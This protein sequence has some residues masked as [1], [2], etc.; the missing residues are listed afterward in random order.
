MEYMF[1]G[2]F[3]L[4][5]INITHFDTSR[6]TSFVSMFDNCCKLKLLDFSDI[7]N[8]YMITPTI[9]LYSLKFHH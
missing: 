8:L 2:C 3:E 4:E 5:S 7:I 9:N 1:S 6:V